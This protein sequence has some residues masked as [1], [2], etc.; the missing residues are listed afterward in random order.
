MDAWAAM[1]CCDRRELWAGFSVWEG[2]GWGSE[3]RS[4]EG[5]AGLKGE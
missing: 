1:E 5:K 2:W 3:G 4:G